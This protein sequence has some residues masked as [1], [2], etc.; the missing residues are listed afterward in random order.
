[1]I[2]YKQA[3]IGSLEDIDEVNG[4]VKGYGSYFG[5]IDS[6]NVS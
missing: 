2:L 3:S 4:I 5:N 1:M 6:K